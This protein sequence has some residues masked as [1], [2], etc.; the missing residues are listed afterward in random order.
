M[1]ETTTATMDG[2]QA[3][4]ATEAATRG[5]RTHGMIGARRGE[6]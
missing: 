6:A 5:I 2:E 1:N 3:D 4:R